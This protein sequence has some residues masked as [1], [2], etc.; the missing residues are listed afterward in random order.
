MK[1]WEEYE[2]FGTRRTVPVD[3]IDNENDDEVVI[4]PDGAA[5]VMVMRCHERVWMN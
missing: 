5:V 4:S 2:A 1:Q 3:P